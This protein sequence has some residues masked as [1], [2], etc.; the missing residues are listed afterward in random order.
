MWVVGV[1]FL[2]SICRIGLN[3]Y[4]EYAWQEEMYHRG[5][6]NKVIVID[7]GHGG[8]DP[9]AMVGSLKE[10]DINLSLA[11][12]LKKE[13]EGMGAKAVL[14]REEKGPLVPEK[15]MSYVQWMENLRRRREF[16][17]EEKGHILISIHSN[18]NNS[19]QASGGIVYYTQFNKN[20]MRL[21]SNIQEQL[22]LYWGADNDMLEKGL[23]VI[24]WDK[25]PSVLMETG[26]LTNP[27]DRKVLSSYAGRKKLARAI[28]VGIKQYC[29]GLPEQ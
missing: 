26:F 28:A 1:I 22:N 27:R 7:P 23:S 8:A 9:G 3:K 2:L 16:A 18:A 24:A 14:T 15:K 4:R 10:A 29:D 25:M 5:I 20:N 11:R 6:K 21:A 12:E 17:L 13:L 19:K